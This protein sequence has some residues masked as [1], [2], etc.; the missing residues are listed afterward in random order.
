MIEAFYTQWKHGLPPTLEHLVLMRMV[1]PSTYVQLEDAYMDK[2]GQMLFPDFSVRTDVES[3]PGRAAFVGR[4]VPASMRRLA[5]WDANQGLHSVF[6][7]PV[8]VL[9]R[10]G[11]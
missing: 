10:I 7:F 11:P 1:D 6:A 2:T 4:T 9:P 3:T 5:S 8:V